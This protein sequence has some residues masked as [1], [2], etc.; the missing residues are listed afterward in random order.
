MYK[1]SRGLG[2]VGIHRSKVHMFANFCVLEFECGLSSMQCSHIDGLPS[3]V[4]LSTLSITVADFEI[5]F[6]YLSTSCHEA[7]VG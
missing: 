2:G 1:V 6:Q 3:I 5:F 4:N 7:L